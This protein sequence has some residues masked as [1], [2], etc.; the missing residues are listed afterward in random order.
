MPPTNTLNMSEPLRLLAIQITSH[1]NY[2]TGQ[3]QGKLL[4]TDFHAVT[5]LLEQPAQD[6]LVLTASKDSL[7]KT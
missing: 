5:F 6:I 2:K 1:L 3:M 4:F 7:I